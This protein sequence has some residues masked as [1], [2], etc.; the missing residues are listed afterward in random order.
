MK[1]TFDI[2]YDDEVFH[3]KAIKTADL[4]SAELERTG[5]LE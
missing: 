5:S 2:L 3:F 4:D 1:I